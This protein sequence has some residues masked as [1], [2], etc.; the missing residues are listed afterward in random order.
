M[1]KCMPV[2]SVLLVMVCCNATAQDTTFKEMTGTYKFAAGS[3]IPEAIVTLENGV[4]TMSSAEG[5]STLERLKG[6]TFNVVS[7]SGIAVFK[8][9]EAKKINGVHIEAAGYIFDGVKDGATINAVN[10]KT[11]CQSGIADIKKHP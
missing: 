10:I 6:D 3:V 8:R 11:T 9:N 2:L 4:L 1:K 5:T 7:F